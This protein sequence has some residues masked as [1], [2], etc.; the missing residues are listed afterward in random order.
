[1]TVGDVRFLTVNGS[2]QTCILDR[3]DPC[4]A[5][6]D[7]AR[8]SDTQVTPDFYAADAAKRLRRRRRRVASANRS[9]TSS[10]IG[11]Q[12]ADVRRRSRCRRDVG[13]LRADRTDRWP[14][15]TTAVG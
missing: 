2:S 4:S 7:P 14:A 1:M 15:S 3:Q 11:G 8:I 13:V 10:S 12:Q 9:P 6:I 5:T